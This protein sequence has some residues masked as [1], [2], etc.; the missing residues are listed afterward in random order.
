MDLQPTLTGATV[1]LRPIEPEDLEPMFLAASDP[2]IWEQH[3]ASDRYQRDVFERFFQDA[4]EWGSSFAILDK[5]S[6][7]IIGSSRFRVME[8]HPEALEIGWTFLTRTYWG[9]KTNP[10]VK[11]MMI[12]HAFKAYGKVIFTIGANNWRSRRAVEK[13]G[14]Q[15]EPEW[16]PPEVTD[17]VVYSISRSQ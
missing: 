12:E 17:K 8:D 14:G 11:Q 1:I 9:G 3:P 10:E 2:L 15:F 7:E 6:G 16:F 13:I 5:Q 4:L